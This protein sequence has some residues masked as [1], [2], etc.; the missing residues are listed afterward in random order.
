MIILCADPSLRPPAGGRRH[1]VPRAAPRP[2][3]CAAP[4]LAASVDVGRTAWVRGNG[5]SGSLGGAGSGSGPCGWQQ[6][7]TACHAKFC[8]HTRTQPAGCSPR[9]LLF[10]LVL[11]GIKGQRY[12]RWVPC[13]KFACLSRLPC[14]PVLCHQISPLLMAACRR[15]SMHWTQRRAVSAAAVRLT[16][17]LLMCCCCSGDGGTCAGHADM[18]Y[19]IHDASGSS[20]L[21]LAPSHSR[22]L[23][24]V[25]VV[26]AL[27]RRRR[28]PC[29]DSFRRRWLR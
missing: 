26:H 11:P 14:G 17:S 28:G 16:L 4:A 21:Q 8:P 2:A 27:A 1:K 24:E 20:Q 22:R 9:P 7:C 12:Q 29:R 15:T 10:G 13:C 5:G 25:E 23:W 6:C 3:C 18:Q 19:T